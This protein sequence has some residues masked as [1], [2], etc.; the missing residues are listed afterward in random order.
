MD[1][2]GLEYSEPL[3]YGTTQNVQNLSQPSCIVKN[4]DLPLS[5]MLVFKWSNFGIVGKSILIF[6]F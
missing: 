6:F 4:A 5:S 3:V 2:N 1:D